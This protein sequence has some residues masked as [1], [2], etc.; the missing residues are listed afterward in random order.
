MKVG[1]AINSAAVSKR[2][3][4]LICLLAGAMGALPYYYE[5]LFVFTFVSLFVQFYIIIKQREERDRIFAPFF[6]YFMGFYT[7]LYLFLS[8]MYPYSRFGFSED[9]AWFILIC[10]CIAIPLVH[11]LV[12]SCLMLFAKF[13][14]KDGWDILGFAALWVIG[15]W[16]LT[17]GML[18]FPW[19]N[20]AVSLT[21]CLPYLQTASLFGKYF[22]TFITIAACYAFAFAT[23]NKK[24]FFA[25][26]ATSII[27]VDFL[28]GTVIWFI[29]AEK[30]DGI[31]V[32]AL[33]GNVLSN[34]KWQSGN[35][36]TI[37]ETYVGMAEEAAIKGAKIIVL[38]ETAIPVGFVPNG[39]VHSAL[40]EISIKYDVTIISGVH[41]YGVENK[42]NAVVAVLPDGSLSE[43][44]DKRHLV[45][46][47]EFI[48]FA[49]ILGEMFPFVGEFNEGTSDLT[50]GIDPI[51]IETQWG[52]VAPLVL[53]RQDHSIVAWT[54]A[55]SWKRDLHLFQPG[56]MHW[57]AI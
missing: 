55:S 1:A 50:E 36:N 14:R 21:G 9:Q 49:D 42:Y 8:E 19:S 15:E 56:R 22:I 10:S 13:F 24:R 11:A 20:I 34:E 33:Q 4:L 52:D 47:G 48:P 38:P 57:A 26:I 31:K 41:Y 40:A 18:A 27:C 44:Y 37:F 7:P 17:L 6:W 43:R 2:T 45:P 28:A 25:L 35:R 46:F 3:S 12:E 16:L 32:A 53:R 5:N 54:R 51:V 29:P 30:S 39:E 23:R